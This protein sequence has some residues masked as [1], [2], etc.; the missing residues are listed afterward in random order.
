MKKKILIALGLI[1]VLGF[2]GLV[3]FDATYSMEDVE[4]YELGN[5][6][7]AQ[8]VLIA[9]QGSEFKNTITDSLTNYLNKAQ[10]FVSVKDVKLLSE[11][12]NDNWDAIVIMHTYEIW[13]PQ[14]DAAAYLKENYEAEKVIVFCTSGDGGNKIEGVDAISGASI[15]K[16]IS[17]YVQQLKSKLKL[18][19]VL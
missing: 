19:L 8:R 17:N 16:D 18:V 3:W 4:S 7:A 1:I 13:E 5:E 9:T 11:V 15:M 10:V 6:N 2:G 12:E 14:E